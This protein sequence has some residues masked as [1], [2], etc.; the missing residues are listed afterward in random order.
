MYAESQPPAEEIRTIC[1]DV[2]VRRG[3]G[4]VSLGWTKMHLGQY[5]E[6]R[7]H[8]RTGLNV[9]RE[10]EQ[11]WIVVTALVGLGLVAVCEGAHAEASRLL[12]ES[13]G[14]CQAAG[15]HGD[16]TEGRCALAYAARG[17]GEL[18]KAQCQLAQAL[19]WANQ[20]RA[21]HVL[22]LALPAAALLLL[23]QG[24]KERA[25]EIYELACTLPAVANSRWYEDV[26]GRPIAEAAAALPPDVAAAAREGGQSTR[27]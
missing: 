4:L 14:E 2:G 8:L 20:R 11:H 21:F 22:V 1:A 10:V 18:E 26:V 9:A 19:Q 27:R 25:V 13:I 24:E 5:R 12:L 16:L 15:K 17:L 7:T 23:D 6:S 3:Y